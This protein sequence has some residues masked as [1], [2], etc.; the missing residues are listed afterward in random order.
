MCVPTQ[1]NLTKG[2]CPS[3]CAKTMDLEPNLLPCCI[4]I[5]MAPSNAYF[6]TPIELVKT[7]VM[8]ETPILA[9]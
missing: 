3:F 1:M 4:V 5:A 6:H 8:R 2:N 7:K 9:T